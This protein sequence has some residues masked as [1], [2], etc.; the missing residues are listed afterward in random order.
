MK[1]A[2]YDGPKNPEPP[3]EN[4]VTTP[5]KQKEEPAELEKQ[6]EKYINDKE[7]VNDNQENRTYVPPPPYIPLIPY[8]QRLK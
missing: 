4:V 1:R 8:P 2:Q 6:R 7:S 5:E 3:K